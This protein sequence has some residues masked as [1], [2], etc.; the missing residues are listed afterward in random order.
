[1]TYHFLSQDSGSDDSRRRE[2]AS[3]L[4]SML[5][6]HLE[7]LTPSQREF[8]ER[9]SEGGPVTVKQLFWLRD[10]WGKFQ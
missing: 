7:E 4:V 8:V 10:L 9:M 2:E 6:D 1:M 3:Q 5:E